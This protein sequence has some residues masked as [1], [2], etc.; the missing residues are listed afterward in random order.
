[1]ASARHRRRR[2]RRPDD[3]GAVTV[4]AGIALSA[5]VLFLGFVLYGLAAGADLIR[6]VDAAREAAR[7][8]ARDE[9]DQA[10]AA[11]ARLA[12]AGAEIRI[13][14]EGEHIQVDVRASP[15]GGVIP[16]FELHAEAFAVREPDG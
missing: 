6:C 14:V 15:A 2:R 4:E 11:A 10:R 12:P 1:M 9:V 8:T 13:D 16:G 3:R 7:L 5:L